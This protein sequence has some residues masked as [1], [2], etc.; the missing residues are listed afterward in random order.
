MTRGLVSG[1]EY[2]GN[3]TSNQGSEAL[4]PAQRQFSLIGRA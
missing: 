3:R 2:M 4:K 1:L